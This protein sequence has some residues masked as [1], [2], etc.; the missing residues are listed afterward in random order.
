ME[1]VDTFLYIHIQIDGG[2][3]QQSF[4]HKGYS[5]WDPQGGGPTELTD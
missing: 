5:I 2:N 1:P 4:V 3:D